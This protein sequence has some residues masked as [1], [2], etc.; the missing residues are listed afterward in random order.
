MLL[1]PMSEESLNRLKL[2]GDSRGRVVLILMKPYS[3][4][5]FSNSRRRTDYCSSVKQR[6]VRSV[7]VSGVYSLVS[8]LTST[9]PISAVHFTIITDAPSLRA[10]PPG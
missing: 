10:R 8:Q 2:W 9:S 3:K 7:S 5:R 6:S 4:F 1:M